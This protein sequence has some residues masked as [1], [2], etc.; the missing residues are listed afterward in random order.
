MIK[1]LSKN[2]GEIVVFD[3]FSLDIEEGK[4]YCIMGPSGCG[5]TTLLRIIANLES[6][7]KGNI[8]LKGKKISFIFQ[9][10]RLLPW[11]T[12]R[13]NLE[14]VCKA[15][16]IKKIDQYL[17]V[18]E[19]KEYEHSY[20]KE[21]S[22]GMKQRVSM[23]RAFLYPHDILLMDEPFQAI[24]VKLKEKLYKEVYKLHKEV[25]NTIIAITHDLEEALFLA[26]KIII[27]SQKPAKILYQASLDIPRRDRNPDHEVLTKVKKQILKYLYHAS[28]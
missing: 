14:L 26:D 17:E 10:A 11:K 12:V 25:N 9:E 18:M 1:N 8:D 19:L 28:V 23:I 21:L 5:K 6:Y 3:D 20:P 4:I 16:E 27:L 22:G 2:F 24:D 13:G 7:D 15:K